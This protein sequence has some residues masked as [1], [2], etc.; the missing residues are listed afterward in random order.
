MLSFGNQ[1]PQWPQL[2][3]KASRNW[4]SHSSARCRYHPLLNHMLDVAAVT[5]LVWGHCLGC[6]RS[7]AGADSIKHVGC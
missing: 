5:G 1:D 2:W 7:G 3:A 6:A 4:S